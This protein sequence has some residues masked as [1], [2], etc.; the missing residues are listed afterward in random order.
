MVR[1]ICMLVNIYFVSLVAYHSKG[2]PV[3][4]GDLVNKGSFL[5]EVKLVAFFD[6]SE[7]PFEMLVFISSFLVTSSIC[8]NARTVSK[9]GSITASSRAL[10]QSRVPSL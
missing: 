1:L 6:G 2:T 10:C 3:W 4:S 9:Y 7:L 5:T 8:T